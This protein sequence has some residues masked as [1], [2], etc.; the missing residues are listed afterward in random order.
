MIKPSID[1][2][3]TPE[4]FPCVIK[5]VDS[6]V[7]IA[8][9]QVPIQEFMGNMHFVVDNNVIGALRESP[10]LFARLGWLLGAKSAEPGATFF[11]NPYFI[12]AE[13]FLSNP[14]NALSKIESFTQHPG[15]F[16]SF[17]ADHGKNLLSEVRKDEL[18]LR[19]QIG[20]L[21]CYLFV[22]REIFQGQHTLKHRV[23]T[24]VRFFQSDI[25]RI[26]LPYV[27]GMLF[28][29]GRDNERLR[30]K[31]SNRSVKA[32]ADGFL[33]LRSEETANPAR[34]V[35][36]RVFDL[37]PFLTSPTLGWKALG[38]IPGR[39]FVLSKDKDIGECLLRIFAWHGEQKEQSRWNLHVNLECL[40]FESRR[41]FEEA[42]FCQIEARPT[43][44]EDIPARMKRLI[45]M[46]LDMLAAP[47]KIELL[48]ALNEFRWFE[49][50][51]SQAKAVHSSPS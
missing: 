18:T 32:W 33:K 45:D 51:S 11:I 38:G 13:Q 28:F 40:H 34:W 7:Y 44:P 24:W 29:F 46:S 16:G 22:M 43:T 19:S 37:L 5:D 30:F 4:L 10:L 6:G 9:C 17:T 20:V 2:A 49:T 21:V 25:P 12:V 42:T 48:A 23:D 26:M 31:G 27:M 41:Q 35:R 8:E 50:T 3:V 36:N 15:T 1:V 39:L 47:Q 14:D